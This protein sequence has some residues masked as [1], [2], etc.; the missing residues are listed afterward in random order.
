MGALHCPVFWP[1]AKKQLT[2]E[3]LKVVE[4]LETQGCKIIWQE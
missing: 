3:F 2:P 1:P 4:E